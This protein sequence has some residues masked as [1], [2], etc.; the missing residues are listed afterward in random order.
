MKKLSLFIGLL[1]MPF[2]NAQTINDA[3]IYAQQ[4]LRGTARYRAMSGAFGALGGDLT[5]ISNNPAG[6]AVF[7]NSYGSLTISSSNTE[8]ISEYGVFAENN[9]YRNLNF[10]QLGAVFVYKNEDRSES[11]GINKIA[12]A[13]TYDQ[14][15]DNRIDYNAFGRSNS[16]I[17]QYFLEQAQGIPLDLLVVPAGSSISNE[18]AFLGEQFGVQEQEAFLGYQSFIIQ[19]NDPD[20]INNTTYS[21]NIGSGVF[22]QEY[23][24]ESTGFN[25]KVTFNAGMQ[26]DKDYYL[27]ANLNIHG[28]NYD[29][30]TELWEGNN[31]DGSNINEV[32]FTNTLS[33]LGSG[34]SAQ[35]GGIAKLSPMLRVGASFETPTWYYIREETVQRLETFSDIDGRAVANPN[36]V[37]IFPEY[38]LKTPGKATGSAAII[39]GKEGLISLDYTYQDYSDTEFDSEEGIDY[40]DLNQ[41]FDTE[42][43]ATATINIGGELRAGHWSYRAGYGYQESPYKDER[44]MSDRERYSFGFGYNFGKFRF[45]FAYDY[46]TQDQN[47]QF[48][49][50]NA[51]TNNADFRRETENLTFTLGM[52][53]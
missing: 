17:D 4:D 35:I 46:T 2:M 45:D 42:L 16:S 41:F 27:G 10:N 48:L 39:F 19:P 21:S 7:L 14:T 1:A 11:T 28:I 20:N 37:N 13:I 49:N 9:S 6:S 23:I 25:G 50:S 15:A 47:I 26:V 34:F 24:Y 32:T 51:F 3:V 52:N 43:Q 40:N 44:I 53:L 12:F 29:R 18:Y 38:I 8:T 30:T 5:A 31:N 36:V 33:T 22:D